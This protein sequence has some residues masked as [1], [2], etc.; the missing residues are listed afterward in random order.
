MARVSA[1]SQTCDVLVIGGGPAGS[2]ISAL[3]SE[4]GWNVTVIEKDHHPRF[5]IGESLLPMNLPILKHLAIP[6]GGEPGP[7]ADGAGVVEGEDDQ[8]ENG[9]IEKGKG[10]NAVSG[11]APAAQFGSDEIPSAIVGFQ[12]FGLYAHYTS[13]DFLV[14]RK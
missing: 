13:S 7:F 5:H 10:Q 8:D 6:L 12:C 9:Q 2:T 4:K 1:K 11:Q 3:L 14:Q